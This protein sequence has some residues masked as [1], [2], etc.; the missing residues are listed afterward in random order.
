MEKTVKNIDDLKTILQ[1]SHGTVR[2]EG[3]YPG[4]EGNWGYPLN[5]DSD[6]ADNNSEQDDGQ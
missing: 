3:I 1:T 2:L 5:I 6:N 4:Y